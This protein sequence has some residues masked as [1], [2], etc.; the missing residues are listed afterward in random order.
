MS[1]R[2]GMTGNRKRKVR[3]SCDFADQLSALTTHTV[4]WSIAKLGWYVSKCIIWPN[5]CLG[6]WITSNV[7]NS[8]DSVV[9]ADPMVGLLLVGLGYP[10]V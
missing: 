1:D 10:P 9:G 8:L 5:P 7:H 2:K 3:V 6:D 4:D